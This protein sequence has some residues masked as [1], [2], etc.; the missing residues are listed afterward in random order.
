M[1]APKVGQRLNR[2]NSTPQF[3]LAWQTEELFTS[4]RDYFKRILGACRQAQQSID[5]EVYIF[6]D[7]SIGR[8]L[9]ATLS[10]AQKRGVRVR[11]LVDGVGSPH[12]IDQVMEKL[13]KSGIES[14]VYHPVPRPFSR[15]W[16]LHFPRFWRVLRM[17][18]AI[19]RRNHKKVFIIDD[20]TALVGGVN[21]SEA[22]LQWNDLGVAV[23]GGGV[24]LLVEAFEENWK[25]S[26]YFGRPILQVLVG[27]KARS[28]VLSPWIFL[29]HTLKLRRE[30]LK[31]LVTRFSRAETRIWIA[32]P[33]WVPG[34]LVIRA[35]IKAAQRGVDVRLWYPEK[36]D[37]RFT[38]WVN[39][40][41]LAPL[42]PFGVRLLIFRQGFLHAK[43][44]VVDQWG[45]IG[46][47]NFN[48]RSF[49]H[50]LE[51]DVVLSRQANVESLARWFE[52]NC[53]QSNMISIDELAQRP[54]LER[55]A[56]RLVLL[57]ERWI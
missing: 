1:L 56:A 18:S 13:S 36:T 53:S 47:S 20:R 48:A 7:D 14:R 45:K 30:R 11:V 41:L 57:F 10:E 16:W 50:D 4:S 37:V 29:N 55:W 49:Y 52:H 22:S 33:Y 21:V 39:E 5:V 32:S 34:P 8:E 17:F 38:R 25:R 6:A 31:D 27:L 19:N 24:G 28:R 46:S 23:E 12:W 3:E 9:L 44:V 51:A 43:A 2:P 35:L 26:F 40:L 42:I 15:L 54:L